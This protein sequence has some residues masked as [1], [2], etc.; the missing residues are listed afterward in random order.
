MALFRRKK[1]TQTP[2][3]EPAEPRVGLPS[4]PPVNVEG[5]RSVADHRAYVLSLVEELPAFGQDL[6]GARGQSLC[7]DLVADLSLPRFD[8]SAMDGYAVRAEDLAGVS[9]SHPR[10][11][12]VVGTV[13]A[14]DSGEIDVEPGTAVKIMT[15]APVPEG[16]DAVV[17][18][19]D[20]DRGSQSAT[21]LVEPRVGANIRRIGEDISE[22]DLIASRGDLL[23]PRQIG[24]LAGIG[25]D[26]VLVRP[27]PR[28]VVVST[29]S[30]LA[31]PGT[32]LAP[33]QIYDSNSYML[34]ALAAEEGALVFRATT[35]SDSPEEVAQTISDQLVRADLILTSGGVS[36]GDH[37][38]IKQVVPQ[39]GPTDFC[40][41]AMQPGKPQG[42]AMIGED[43]TPMIMLPGNPVS[44]FVSFEV[45]VRPAIRKMM[46]M[47]PLVRPTSHAITRTSITSAPGKTQYQRG[48]VT[49]TEDGIRHVTS[50]GGGGSHKLGDLAR[51]NAL[52]VLGPEVE[53]VEA[54]DPVEIMMV[55]GE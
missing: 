23:G 52:I 33:G 31:A 22:G 8:N 46:G 32:E 20:T 16:L 4:R 13:A 42:M 7:E 37:D 1:Q 48:V 26:Q 17:R 39:L 5:L 44:S 11:L 36:Q 41:V 27:R 55:E 2:V 19:E 28:V 53:R 6:L 12:P 25:I 51:S 54:G 24:M 15:G 40:R 50:M 45:F 38:V 21:F 30:E 14:G 29:G 35:V 18:Y 34:A 9:R 3:T 43:R 49:T 47:L 10:E